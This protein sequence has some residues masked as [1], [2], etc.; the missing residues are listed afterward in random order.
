MWLIYIYAGTD[1]NKIQINLIV[2]FL[3][4]SYLLFLGLFTHFVLTELKPLNSD[5]LSGITV[6]EW[7]IYVWMFSL[8]SQE[9]EQVSK[10]SVIF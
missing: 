7:I 1:C 2:T 5:G 3:Q 6:S 8:A 9:I 4:M 10:Q